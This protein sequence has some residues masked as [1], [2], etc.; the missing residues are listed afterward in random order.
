MLVAQL[1]QKYEKERRAMSD[2]DRRLAKMMGVKWSDDINFNEPEW[3]ARLM[4]WVTNQGSFSRFKEWVFDEM[5]R[6]GEINKANDFTI[7]IWRNL[8]DMVDRYFEHSGG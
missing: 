8:P 2:R 6:S 7:Y 4:D 1:R 3:R 5:I